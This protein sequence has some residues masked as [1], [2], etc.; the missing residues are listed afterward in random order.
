MA[1]VAKTA[2]PPSTAPFCLPCIE[3]SSRSHR[4]ASPSARSFS[5]F[6][7]RSKTAIVLTSKWLDWAMRDTTTKKSE[8]TS[9]MRSKLPAKSVLPRAAVTRRE[10][11]PSPPGTANTGRTDGCAFA[12]ANVPLAEPFTVL[13]DPALGACFWVTCVE[14]TKRARSSSDRTIHCSW[15]SSTS[16]VNAVV[17]ESAAFGRSLQSCSATRIASLTHITWNFARSPCSSKWRR[18]KCNRVW[19]AMPRMAGDALVIKCS[20]EATTRWASAARPLSRSTAIEFATWRRRQAPACSIVVG[21]PIESATSSAPKKLA[22][23]AGTGYSATARRRPPACSATIVD[24]ER[25]QMLYACASRRE[26]HG[27]RALACCSVTFTPATSFA[28]GGL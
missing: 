5:S 18:A 6:R 19:P 26:S 2:R 14:G 24:N 25:T 13:G 1:A 12:A 20:A 22:A 28:D 9:T 21:A 17:K 8:H 23:T 4:T 27:S 15:H 10:A 3:A 11:S 7:T 16:D